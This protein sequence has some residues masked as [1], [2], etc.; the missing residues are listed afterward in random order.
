LKEAQKMESLGQLTGGIAHDFN[1]LLTAIR[2]NLDLLRLERDPSQ[3]QDKINLAR[4]AT[5]RASELVSRLLSFSKPLT[6]HQDADVQ[7]VLNDMLSILQASL[8]PKVNLQI[9]AEN[10]DWHVAL[11]PT[12][13]E[14]VLL[15][16][17]LNA[18]DALPASGG[19]IIV[20][21]EQVQRPK[22]TLA[23]KGYG[24]NPA[25]EF[26]L[27]RVRDTGHG[28]PKEVGERIFE[29]FFT[30]KAPEKGT[31]LGLTMAHRIITDAGGWM[32]YDSTLGKGTEFRIY[33]PRSSKAENRTTHADTRPST[34]ALLTPA[35]GDGTI[36]VVDDETSVRSIAVHM[37]KY[38]GYHVMEAENGEQALQLLDQN[39]TPID[40]ILMDV[41]MPKL[42]G[43]DTFKILRQRGNDTPV[44]VCSGFSIEQDEFMS[45]ASGRTGPIEVIQKPYAMD[46]LAKAVARAVEKG[47]N[48]LAA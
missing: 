26:V 35:T 12:Q 38:L 48:A 4:Q 19:Q 10:I 43:R 16:L 40:A 24:T 33:L 39:S 17:C 21:S 13:L 20:H 3:T 22:I 46:R 9:H 2:G 45:L 34:S 1:N 31:G 29:A 37:L 47:H 30:T 14:Q 5:M 27:V 25:G 18:R 42:S 32:E 28:I 41:Y 6:K 15:N 36:L 11:D 23:E 7:R 8:D 44:I